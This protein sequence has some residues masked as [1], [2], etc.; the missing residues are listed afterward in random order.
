MMGLIADM[1]TYTYMKTGIFA[2][3]LGSAGVSAADK[4]GQGVG[5][6]VFGFTLAA[7]GFNATAGVQPEAVI[8]AVS[9][10]HIWIPAICFASASAA[11]A[12]LFDI[13]RN[14]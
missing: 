12:M 9:W 14:R 7:A 13:E 2:A 3:G 11:I 4:L 1:V 8:A 6:A 5:S 10:A